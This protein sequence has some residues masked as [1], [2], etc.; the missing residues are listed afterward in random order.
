MAVVLGV[1]AGAAAGVGALLPALLLLALVGA[2]L[3]VI[4]IEHHR[5]PDRLVFPLAVGAPVLAV[6]A[7][8]VRQDWYPLLRAAE[9]AAAVFAVLYVL[10]LVAPRSF[11]YGDVKLGGVLGGYLGWFGWGHVYYGCSPGS[12]SAPRWRSCCCVVGRAGRKTPLPFGPM[13]VLG[14]LLVLAFDLVPMLG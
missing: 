3:T 9:A 10:I 11:G 13:L 14:A 8:A 1:L 7:A 12:C 6:V 4:D 2:P 5:L